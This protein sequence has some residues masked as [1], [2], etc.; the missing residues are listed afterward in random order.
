MTHPASCRAAHPAQGPRAAPGAAAWCAL[1]LVFSAAAFPTDAWPAQAYP[2]KA[3]RIVVPFSA[4][5]GTDIIARLLAQ[6]LSEAWGQ[7]V[8]VD[9]RAGG[10]AV[11]GTEIV[12]KSG[13]D[14]YTLLLT[15][16]PHT[17][18]PVLNAR[19]PY[20]ALRDFAAVTMVASA[21][22][23]VVV[24]PSL[25]VRSV[26]E[27]IAFAA[28]RPGQLS[29]GSSG[30]GGPQHLAGELFKSMARIDMVHVPY[31]GSAPATTDLLAGQVQVGFSS[32]LT[33]LPHV[34]TSGMRVD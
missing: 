7:Q 22:L 34:K 3:V 31:K 2:V 15:A 11:I 24:H 32:M 20:D 30:N 10:G 18:N 14:G 13:P 1:L 28:A 21:P 9:N 25:P 12:A 6:K 8:V 26:R 23:I 27:L 29:Y 33:V 5:G 16:N 17:A 4:G 19:L